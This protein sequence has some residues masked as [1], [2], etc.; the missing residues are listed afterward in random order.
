MRPARGGGIS[1]HNDGVCVRV[2]VQ[3]SLT[4]DHASSVSYG[5]NPHDKDH[6]CLIF[7]RA[8]LTLTISADWESEKVVGEILF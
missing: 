6:A 3:G 2:C 4:A 7:L 1:S 8:K 5:N